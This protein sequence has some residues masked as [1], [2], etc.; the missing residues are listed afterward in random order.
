MDM[1]SSY[2]NG[3]FLYIVQANNNTNNMC[4]DK[5]LYYLHT[6]REE[7][8]KYQHQQIKSSCM[9]V[10]LFGHFHTE[11]PVNSGQNK[12]HTHHTHIAHISIL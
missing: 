2:A 3:N 6:R 11:V 8:K 7:E 5:S 10:L 12:E 1:I 4:E 9:N